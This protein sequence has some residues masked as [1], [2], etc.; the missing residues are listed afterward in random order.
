MGSDIPKTRRGQSNGIR[1]GE[2]EGRINQEEEE[3]ATRCAEM[4]ERE[5]TSLSSSSRGKE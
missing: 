2:R 4:D 5:R 1:R 3:E